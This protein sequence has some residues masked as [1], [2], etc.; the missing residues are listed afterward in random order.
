MSI[1]SNTTTWPPSCSS[2]KQSPINL[3]QSGAKPCNLSC[4][5]VM[6]DG[7]VTQADVSVSDEALIL[8]SSSSLG[9]CKFR[10]ESYVCQGLSINHPS[11]HTI[12][13]VQADGEVTAY[14]KKPTGELMCMSTLFRIN[15][16][17]TASFSFFKQFVPYALTSGDTKLTMRDWSLTALVPPEAS[18][19][20]YDG[21]TLVPPCTPC[22]WVVFKSMINMDQGDFAYLVRNAEAGS[23]PIQG[24]GDREVFFNDTNNIPGVM[25]HDNK[26]YLRLKPTGNTK[27]NVAKKDVSKVDLKN[28][29]AQSKAD[30]L[31]EAKHPTTF[32]GQLSKDKNDYVNKYGYIG[33]ALAIMAITLVVGGYVY[34]KQGSDTAPFKAEFAKGWALW[35]R[36]KLM[37]IWT[38]VINFFSMVLSYIWSVIVWIYQWTLGF[39]PW[40]IQHFKD[41]AAKKAAERAARLAARIPGSGAEV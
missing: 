12:E 27:V 16:T 8:S 36:E 19:Y 33:L 3:S 22:E 41:I 14:F 4:D 6:D 5:L 39:V 24:L 34:G 11:H 7:M 29:T 32:L 15:S 9:S 30:A 1:F 10:G 28:N 35:T 37:W 13:G 18:Y 20:I 25:P 2:A 23:R 40:A 38:Y 31:E 21:S 26:L 17:Q